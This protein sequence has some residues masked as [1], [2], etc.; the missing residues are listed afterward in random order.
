MGD[1]VTEKRPAKGDAV[2]EAEYRKARGKKI[3]QEYDKLLTAISQGLIE[4]YSND[5]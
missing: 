2:A 1:A 5:E 4:N 3:E